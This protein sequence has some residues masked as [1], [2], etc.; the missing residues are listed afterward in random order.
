MRCC[1]LAAST[2]VFSTELRG[3]EARLGS[4]RRAPHEWSAFLEQ[5]TAQPPRQPPQQA[6]FP[7][8]AVHL[9]EEGGARGP[10]GLVQGT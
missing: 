6:A 8:S 4:S 1:R 2:F 3:G 9:P 7:L 10:D 5:V